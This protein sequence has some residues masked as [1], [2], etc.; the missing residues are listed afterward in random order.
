MRSPR[1]W[2]YKGRDGWRWRLYGRNGRIVA[3][4][5]EAYVSHRNAKRAAFNVIELMADADVIAPRT[6]TLLPEERRL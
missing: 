1:L 2:V 3:D 4:G 6:G 5:A